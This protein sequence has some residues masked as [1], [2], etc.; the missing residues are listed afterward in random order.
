M[1]E[2]PHVQFLHPKL[3]SPDIRKENIAEKQNLKLLRGV[4]GT[5]C[6]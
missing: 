6:S 4:W 2:Y 1:A 5:A 3:P